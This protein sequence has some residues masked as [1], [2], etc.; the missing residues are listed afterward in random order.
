MA[1]QQMEKILR[2]LASQHPCLSVH[3]RHRLGEVRVGEIA[4]VVEALGPP[5][6]R[7]RSHS[8]PASWIALK[9]DVPIWKMKAIDA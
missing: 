9:Q 3:V 2:E 8:P 4:I 6:A 7:R 5:I 1:E